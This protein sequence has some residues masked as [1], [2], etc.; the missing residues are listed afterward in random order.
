[1]LLHARAR[2]GGATWGTEATT[3][4]AT[5]TTAEFVQ[6][7][8]RVSLTHPWLV[9]ED[10]GEVIG[11]AYASKH[12]ERA[13]YR[14]AADVAV[15]VAD[16]Q[17]RRGVGRSL[18]Q[19]LFRLLAAQNL[20]VACAGITL[21]NDASIGLHR[22]CGFQPVGVYRRIG[23]KMGAWWDV[24]WWQLELVDAADGPPREPGPPVR[25]PAGLAVLRPRIPSAAR[26]FALAEWPSR[27]T[28]S[29][30]TVGCRASRRDIA[31]N[32]TG[33]CT[34]SSGKEVSLLPPL[35]SMCRAGMSRLRSS[36][37]SRKRTKPVR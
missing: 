2:V 22:V 21:P 19:M 5:P 15:Y 16:G 18:Y 14:W 37:K 30:G 13:C 28:A 29:T 10:G 8:E 31:C 23:W 25:L 7:I 26:R 1:M 6:R 3:E 17:R 32:A 27:P 9:A 24:A 34:P 20:R 4:R 36:H 33:P 35:P 11:Y 12:R